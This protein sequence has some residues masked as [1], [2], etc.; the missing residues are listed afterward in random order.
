MTTPFQHLQSEAMKLSDAERADLADLLWTSVTERAAVDA[1]W[2]AELGRRVAALDAR[3]TDSTSAEEVF[4]EA[5]RIVAD[6]D[7]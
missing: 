6:D 1:A 7:R 5:C 4:D 2:D 3:H